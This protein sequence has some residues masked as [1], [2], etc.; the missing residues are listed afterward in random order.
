VTFSLGKWTPRLMAPHNRPFW[1]ILGRSFGTMDRGGWCPPPPSLVDLSWNPSP[2]A[3][4]CLLPPTFHPKDHCKKDFCSPHMRFC[5]EAVCLKKIQELDRL[6]G[7]QE[8]APTWAQFFFDKS[9]VFFVDCSCDD[10]ILNP[11]AT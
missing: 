8:P 1:P 6:E 3:T 7:I 5:K 10:K 4:S 9:R 2:I 11:F